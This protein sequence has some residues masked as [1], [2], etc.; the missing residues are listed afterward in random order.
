M[1]LPLISIVAVAD[2]PIDNLVVWAKDG[3]KVAYALAEKPKVTFTET[4]LVIT[5]N[6]IEVNYVLE[7][8]A[9]FTYEK[10]SSTRIT[11]LENGETS[12]KLDGELLLFPSLKANSTI[13]IYSTNGTLVFKQTVHK[14][15]E[16]AFS[17]LNLN[18]GVYLVYVNGLTYKIIKR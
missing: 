8:M 17:V 11:N 9:R 12:F 10:S 13:A 7:N 4:D 6:G 3:T 15:G 18:T 2:E 14:N 16:Y 5:S 1:L